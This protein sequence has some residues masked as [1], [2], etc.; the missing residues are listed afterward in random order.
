[1]YRQ[2]AD[3]VDRLLRGAT[4]GDLPIQQPT[5]FRMTVN[6]KAARGLGLELSTTIVAEADEVIE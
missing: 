2:S 5:R 1:L 6:V 3:Y 4:P